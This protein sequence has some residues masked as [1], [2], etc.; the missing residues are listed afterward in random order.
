MITKKDRYN[1]H[2]PIGAENNTIQ[3]TNNKAM[4]DQ[5]FPTVASCNKIAIYRVS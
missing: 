4:E 1:R 3:G 5:G 2:L